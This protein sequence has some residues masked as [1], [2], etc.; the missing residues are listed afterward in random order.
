MILKDSLI[1]LEIETEEN[2]KKGGLWRKVHVA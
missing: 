2:G 1:I